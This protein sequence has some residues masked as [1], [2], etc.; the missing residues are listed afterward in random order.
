MTID[1]LL[2]AAG[3][4][5]RH[6]L[7]AIA[8]PL[9]AERGLD[10]VHGGYVEKLDLRTAASTHPTR[11]FRVQA[12]Q[13]HVFAALS[14]LGMPG[15]RAA[16]DHG[17]DFVLGPGRHP[18]GAFPHLYDAAG[19][20]TDGKRDLYDLAFGLF[21]LAHAHDATGRA[22]LVVEAHALLD[23]I[24]AR[25]AHPAGGFAEALPAALPRR[26]NPHMHLLEACL[27][28]APLDRSGR[29]AALG[30]RLL[31]L[32]ETV[33]F[34]PEHGALLEFLGDD[35]SRL[36]PPAGVTIEPGHHY[37]WVWLLAEARRVLGRDLP[38]GTRLY[39]LAMR[40]FDGSSGLPVNE[41][42]LDGA[43]LHAGCRLWPVTEWLKAE[44]ALFEAETGAEP[45]ATGIL[46]A[47]AA[48]QRF[49]DAPTQGL[50]F[51]R[52]DPVTRAFVDEPAPASSFYHI[53]VALLELMRVSAAR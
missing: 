46:A 9:W 41:T 14:K 2:S 50:W 37:E 18:D 5:A 25:M 47:N 6:W 11:R 38:H 21:A 36:P 34:E 3:A 51:D 35:W 7:V 10:R 20:I 40:D 53:V 30:H 24:E 16:L 8:G 1:P 29:F 28:W 4:R 26:Q 52:Y 42:T 31:D 19:A 39:A 43:V 32:F 44:I 27:A 22:D 49:L 45:R 48:L 23:F 33:F 12:R 13:I 15:A 17:L